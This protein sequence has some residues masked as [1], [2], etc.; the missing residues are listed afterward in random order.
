MVDLAAEFWQLAGDPG[1][2][3]RDLRR[4]VH[5]ATPLSVKFLPGLSVQRVRTWLG[6]LGVCC[7]VPDGDRAL[8]A[9]LFAR[10]SC[11]FV[12]LDAADSEA[13]HRFSLAHEIGHFLRH[14]LQP[15]GRAVAHFGEGI[16][17]PL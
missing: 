12:F 15:R 4:A 5:R 1:P 10:D 11:G 17:D 7:A 8:R 9:C 3:P 13:E 2:F 14:Y 16:L 6:N